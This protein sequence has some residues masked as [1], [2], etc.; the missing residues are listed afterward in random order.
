M[1]LVA[2]IGFA[3]GTLTTLAYL[4]Q[5]LHSFRT[6]S[7]RDLSMTMLVSLNI[8]LL[9][10][11]VYGF[12]IH[13]LPLILTNALTLLLALPLLVM[14]VRFHEGTSGATKTA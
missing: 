1:S 14:K 4:P 11:V 6:R 12:W 9:L 10:W 3:A 7:V 8:G 5:A 13:S 2:A